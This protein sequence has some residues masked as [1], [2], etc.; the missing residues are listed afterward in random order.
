MTIFK[1]CMA[2]MIAL[3]VGAWAERAKVDGVPETQSAVVRTQHAAR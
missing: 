3:V 1:L 2:A